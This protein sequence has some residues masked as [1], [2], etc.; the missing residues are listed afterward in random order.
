VQPDCREILLAARAASPFPRPVQC[1]RS[2]SC[3]RDCGS[4]NFGFL[5]LLIQCWRALPGRFGELPAGQRV[6]RYMG[7]LG[8]SGKGEILI[9]E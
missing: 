1:R 3:H 5:P 8:N 7:D 4:H 9:W 2:R 6:R